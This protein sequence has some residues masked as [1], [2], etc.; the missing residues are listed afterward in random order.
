MTKRPTICGMTKM[1]IDSGWKKK[2]RG[3]GFIYTHPSL[4]RAVVHSPYGVFYN[5]D[6]FDS[7][8]IAKAYALTRG[9]TGE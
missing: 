6:K 2:R 7:I 9:K 5:G 4:D 3:T 8:D 1:T